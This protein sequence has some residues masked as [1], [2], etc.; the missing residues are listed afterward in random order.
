MRRNVVEN[1][2]DAEKI[3]VTSGLK[4][5]NREKECRK[6]GVGKMILQEAEAYA[7]S[8][9]CT[10]VLLTTF[11]FQARPFYEKNGYRVVFEQVFLDTKANGFFMVK[12]L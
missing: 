8:K 9:N 6:G 4:A 11:A 2:T 10:E 3:N 5:F 7:R 1:P 12:S